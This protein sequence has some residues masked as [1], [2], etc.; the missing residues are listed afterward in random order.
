MAHEPIRVLYAREH[1]TVYPGQGVFL[2]GPDPARVP[3]AE[4]IHLRNLRGA[5]RNP[6]RLDRR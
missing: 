3:L 4:R 6:L 2:A 1:A 5:P